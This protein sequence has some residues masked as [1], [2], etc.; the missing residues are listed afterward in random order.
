[1]IDGMSIE[2]GECLAR[3]FFNAGYQ[4]A[5]TRLDKS[6]VIEEDDLA[7]TLV[8]VTNIAF[9]CELAFKVRSFPRKSW[10]KI[11]NKHN[12]QSM[13]QHLSEKEQEY[14]EC[15]TIAMYI[16]NADAKYD[17]KAFAEDLGASANAFVDIRYWHELPGKGK[18][19]SARVKFMAC[20][21][22]AV[23]QWLDITRKGQF[24]GIELRS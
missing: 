18:G 20:F 22:A 23:M 7:P 19:K 16:D 2:A 3:A 1:M 14:I 10:H 4:L 17:H 6:D 12:L 15:L 8:G 13:F 5:T 11:A 21:G 9:A 24:P